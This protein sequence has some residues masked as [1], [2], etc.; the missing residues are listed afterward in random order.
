MQ[1]G[2]PGRPVVTNGLSSVSM[3]EATT[4]NGPSLGDNPDAKAVGIDDCPVIS[5]AP[6]SIV[7][8]GNV[9]GPSELG[10]SAHSAKAIGLSKKRVANIVKG[11]RQRQNVPWQLLSNARWQHHKSRCVRRHTKEDPICRHLL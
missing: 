2:Q 10:T 3:G 6:V 5:E 7:Y 8:T 4:S 11:Q 1:Y 9:I